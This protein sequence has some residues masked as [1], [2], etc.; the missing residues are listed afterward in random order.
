MLGGLAGALSRSARSFCSPLRAGD[1]KLK[2][3]TAPVDLMNLALVA[4]M[5]V[6]SLL[7]ALEGM[8]PVAAAVGDLMRVQPLEV[9]A[10]PG[11]PD[12]GRDTVPASTCR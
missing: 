4:L 3:Y 12:G 5:G 7:I 6:L 9:L 2:P 8:E 1:A 10:A 11:G